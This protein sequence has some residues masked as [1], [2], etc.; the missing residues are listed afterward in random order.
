MQDQL[1]KFVTPDGGVITAQKNGP[2][3]LPPH[4]LE[5]IRAADVIVTI[6]SSEED[7]RALFVRHLYAGGIKAPQEIASHAYATAIEQAHDD[8][9]RQVRGEPTDAQRYRAL[10]EFATLASSDHDRFDKVNTMV[11]QFEDAE[12]AEDPAKRT[13][14]DHD[15]MADFLV[16]ALAETASAAVDVPQPASH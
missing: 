9:V 6:G 15:R 11:Q 12:M 3:G 8:L 2:E 5:H 7:D 14:A 10:R 1:T 13:G 16:H 4:L